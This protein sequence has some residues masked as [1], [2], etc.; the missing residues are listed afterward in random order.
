MGNKVVNVDFRKGLK[1]LQDRY[2][3]G[4]LMGLHRGLR[5]SHES[6][7]N[8]G[9]VSAS[10]VASHVL[11]QMINHGSPLWWDLIDLE[12]GSLVSPDSSRDEIGIR[13]LAKM[14]EKGEPGVSFIEITAI[15]IKNGI[16]DTESYFEADKVN[17]YAT[18]WMREFGM[19][20]GGL[21]PMIERI[22]SALQESGLRVAS[23]KHLGRTIKIEAFDPRPRD[24]VT[25]Y[26]VFIRPDELAKDIDIIRA[27][28]AQHKG[29][30]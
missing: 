14:V 8:G 2:K 17:K 18:A 20:T 11:A 21:M 9:W 28:L 23:C 15:E 4:K 25:H 1:D 16:E 6:A 5:K 30:H 24:R 27:S 3:P 26:S 13:T 7:L 19:P 10:W 29:H 22:G 12:F